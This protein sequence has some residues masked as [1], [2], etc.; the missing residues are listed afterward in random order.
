[1]LWMERH[2]CDIF[3]GVTY[4]PTSSSIGKDGADVSV[5]RDLHIAQSGIIKSFY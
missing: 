4:S 2:D 3:F 5:G 1:M